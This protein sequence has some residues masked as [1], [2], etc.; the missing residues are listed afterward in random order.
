MTD[1]RKIAYKGFNVDGGNNLECRGKRYE[2]GGTASV[3]GPLELCKN[4]I[5]FCW[6]LNDVHE[7]YDLRNSVICEIEV[8]G[9]IV[10]QEDMKKSCT[11]K[12]RVLRALTKEQ[13]LQISNTGT[14]NTG[15]MNSGDMN[16]GNRNTGNGNTGNRNTGNWNSGDWNSGDW[17]TGNWNTGYMNRCDYSNGVFCTVTPKIAIF[18]MPSDMTMPEFLDSELYAAIESS[19]FILTEWAQYT[20]AEKEHDKAKE[21]T[22]GRLIEH[23]PKE[24]YAGWWAGMSPENREIIKSMQN[25]DKDV[26]RE[27]TFGIEVEEG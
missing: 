26:F 20:A 11:D 6:N 23:T 12:I 9:E 10:N 18:N 25:F 27:A 7:H 19:P 8:L 14:C 5:H 17:N 15:L 3:P 1:D 13:V 24:A 16:S 4:G 21:L 22:G 2:V